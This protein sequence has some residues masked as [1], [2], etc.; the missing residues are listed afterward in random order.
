MTFVR[1]PLQAKCFLTG[2]PVSFT[3]CSCEV[4]LINHFS[5]GAKAQRCKIPG[6][7]SH[8]GEEQGWYLHS[9]LSEPLSVSHTGV[10]P[11]GSSIDTIVTMH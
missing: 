9:V 2:Y 6:S 11:V 10:T 3:L 1:C 7:G 5:D 8:G 4:G